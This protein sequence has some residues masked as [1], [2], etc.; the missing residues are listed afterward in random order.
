MLHM[1][2]LFL[3]MAYFERHNNDLLWLVVEITSIWLEAVIYRFDGYG[4]L[5]LKY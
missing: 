3:L 5:S 2:T 1:H 4:C